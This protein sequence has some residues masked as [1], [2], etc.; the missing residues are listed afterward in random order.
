VLEDG[1]HARV[2]FAIKR[3]RRTRDTCRLPPLRHPR[4]LQ[5]LGLKTVAYRDQRPL[6]LDLARYVSTVTGRRGCVAGRG[7]AR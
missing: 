5:D 4:A 2:D 6:A 7:P 3:D 1:S